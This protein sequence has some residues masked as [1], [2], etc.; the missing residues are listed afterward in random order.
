MRQ[1]WNGLGLRGKVCGPWLQSTE[2]GEKLAGVVLL[3]SI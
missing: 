3:V 2:E 1:G